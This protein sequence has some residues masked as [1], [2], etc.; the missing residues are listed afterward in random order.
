MRHECFAPLRRRKAVGAVGLLL[1]L[2]GAPYVGEAAGVGLVLFFVGA[3]V[4]HLRAGNH[5]LA[6]PLAYLASS[7]ASLVL[8]V[9][10]EAG[11]SHAQGG[12][13]V[14]ADGG[15]PGLG[16]GAE[17]L[18]GERLDVLGEA[19]GGQLGEPGGAEPVGGARRPSRSSDHQRSHV[20]TGQI[21]PRQ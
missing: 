12:Q 7:I 13:P 14:E 2:A 5:D 4:T 18:A 8:A 3:I 6:F 9:A 21:G 16:V 17:A 10:T 19:G 1:G 15:G 20:T 11:P